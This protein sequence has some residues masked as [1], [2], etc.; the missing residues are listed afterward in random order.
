MQTFPSLK[1]C[2]RPFAIRRALR[3]TV[4]AALSALAFVAPQLARTEDA[5][6]SANEPRML[7]DL[8]YVP[9]GHERQKLDL[10]L[11]AAPKGPLLVCIH[12]G[13]WRG[14]S[15]AHPPG[16]QLLAKG[17][18]IASV[19][20]RFSQDAIFPA[21][22]EDCKA[23]IRWLRAHAKEYGFDGGRIGAIGDSA[24]GHLVALLAVTGQMRDFDVGSNLDQSS[25]IQCAID[26]YGPSDFEAYDPALPTPMV[27]RENPDS[28]LSLLFG[29]TVSKKR[30]LAR[31]ASPVAWVTKD[32]APMLILQGT[33]DPLVP[34]EQSEMLAK[35]LKDAGA[36]VKLD[37]VEGAGHGGPE[38][39]SPGRLKEIGDFLAAHLGG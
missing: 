1:S 38:F 36:E 20:Y 28:V 30:E 29:G 27:Q 24:G 23:A 3:I 14:G 17:Y 13:G 4:L 21:Q 7:R 26:L 15:K 18:S 37:I 25:A 6:P 19:E 5:P 35:K 8:A 22:I 39:G 12:G 32:A 9:D 11:P 33:K 10:Y 31:K 2:P 34:M 16:L